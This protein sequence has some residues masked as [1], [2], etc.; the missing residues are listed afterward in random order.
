M[1]SPLRIIYAG[2]DNLGEVE[3]ISIDFIELYYK[4]SKEREDKQKN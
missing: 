2:S 3:L 4:G 1:N